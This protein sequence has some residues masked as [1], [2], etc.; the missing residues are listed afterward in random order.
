M[1]TKET[2]KENSAL[3]KVTD[4][5]E[6]AE[7]SEEKAKKAMTGLGSTKPRYFDLDCE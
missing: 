6:D 3:D 1:T 4:Y 5:V 2:N 7:I